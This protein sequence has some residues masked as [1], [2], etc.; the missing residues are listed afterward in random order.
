M[1]VFMYS[2]YIQ[3]SRMDQPGMIANSTRGQL[4]RGTVVMC[5]SLCPLALEDLVSRDGFD[6]SRPASARS[7]SIPP[8]ESDW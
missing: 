6:R 7:F 1:Y 8:A 3:S 2:Q 4:N 5:F